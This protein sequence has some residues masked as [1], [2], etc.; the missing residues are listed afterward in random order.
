MTGVM[1]IQQVVSL[2]VWT[3]L[4]IGAL[5]LALWVLLYKYDHDGFPF[6]TGAFGCA[7]GWAL[8]EWISRGDAPLSGPEIFDLGLG[9][10]VLGFGVGVFGWPSP[11]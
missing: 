2:L 3:A 9:G 7:A 8:A 5:E 4:V 6:L 10:L 11:R 1:A